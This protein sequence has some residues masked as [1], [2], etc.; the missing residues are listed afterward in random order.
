MARTHISSV[1]AVALAVVF[2]HVLNFNLI[3]FQL[4]N[5]KCFQSSEI[6]AQLG[7]TQD[8]LIAM[9][10]ILGCDYGLVGIKGIGKERALEV[11]QSWPGSNPLQK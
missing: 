5:M 7:L 3:F 1:I 8:H 4:E 11:L 10:L 2:C 6:E 9:A